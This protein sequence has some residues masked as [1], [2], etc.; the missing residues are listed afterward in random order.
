MG[1]YDGMEQKVIGRKKSNHSQ[2]D[3]DFD[4]KNKIERNILDKNESQIIEGEDVENVFSNNLN[5]NT[6]IGLRNTSP[7]F[8]G[9]NKGHYR[10][11]N[12]EENQLDKQIQELNTLKQNDEDF[13][14]SQ[15]QLNSLNIKSNKSKQKLK[16][17][18]Q[19]ML[20]RKDLYKTKK[21]FTNNKP[22]NNLSSQQIRDN[23]DLRNKIAI[24][25]I[26]KD[27][28]RKQL[29]YKQNLKLSTK[30]PIAKTFTYKQKKEL[31]QYEHEKLEEI[32]TYNMF[33]FQKVEDPLG[34]YI[35]KII[36][37]SYQYYLE[38]PCKECARN[39][40]KG[41]HSLQC[42]SHHHKIKSFNY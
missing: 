19:P 15:S 5:Y 24:V 38:R 11:D 29:E 13:K 28:L 9:D 10:S 1:Y 37:N 18:E 21:N 27:R 20:D 7:D 23:F 26:E 6:G 14:K 3:N 35:D 31:E 4:D 33:P 32:D 8:G 39:F 12:E 42:C 40:T 2:S 34:N 22:I 36:A 25:E 16:Y 17:N 41:G 30:K